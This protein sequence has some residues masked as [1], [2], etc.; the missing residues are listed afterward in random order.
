M[1]DVRSALP[2]FLTTR[3]GRI[4]E[5][6]AA[7][8]E[9]SGIPAGDAVGS[10]CWEVIRGYDAD[11]GL[12][13]HPG[14][15]IARLAREGWPVR[16]TDLRVHMPSGVEQVTV[17]TIV[18]GEGGD[19]VVL[20]P[21]QPPRA[22]S[23]G[24]PPPAA[25][26]ELTSRQREILALLADGVRAKEIAMRLSLSVRTVRNHINALLRRLEVQSQLEAAAKARELGLC[27]PPTPGAPS[28]P[29]QRR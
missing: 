19:A 20:H 6:N 16:C 5:W 26:P 9:L 8:E 14:C 3:S 17:S 23:A 24:P 12:V 4:V 18:V 29:A 27:R 15:S 2:L 25:A 10:D 22:E 21:M 7:A 28:R 11:G 13:C 1:H